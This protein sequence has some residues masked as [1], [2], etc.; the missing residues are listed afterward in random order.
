MEAKGNGRG[1][2]TFFR[3]KDPVIDLA[4]EVESDPN[5]KDFIDREVLKTKYYSAPVRIHDLTTN[6]IEY[7]KPLVDDKGRL[8]TDYLLISV[9]PNI[10]DRKSYLRGDTI[11]VISG[12]HG[13]ATR[14]LGLLLSSEF[15]LANLASEVDKVSNTGDTKYWQALIEV[16]QIQRRN[17][18]DLPL[19]LGEYVHVRG[20]GINQNALDVWINGLPKDFEL[21]PTTKTISPRISRAFSAETGGDAVGERDLITEPNQM[22]SLE[23]TAQDIDPYVAR[24][25]ASK[26]LAYYPQTVER[27]A[28]AYRKRSHA[29]DG[30]EK[31][32]AIVGLPMVL[33]NLLYTYPDKLQTLEAHKVSHERT[34]LDDSLR[35]LFRQSIARCV[36]TWPK[37]FEAFREHAQELELEETELLAQLLELYNQNDGFM[38]TV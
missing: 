35:S 34:V 5:T 7:F 11:T 9:V 16:D 26:T 28:D 38:R 37:S 29:T 25:I 3:E 19:G 2:Y 22:K 8:I 33:C 31:E 24:E 10:L 20:V 1:L 23:T 32:R 17:G 27:F 21:K 6:T 30:P 15:A 12:A 18:T 36:Q 14:S 4:F 13:V